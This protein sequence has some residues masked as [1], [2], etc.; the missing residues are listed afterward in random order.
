MN[1][2][3][4]KC[5][6]DTVLRSVDSFQCGVDTQCRK[7][8]T[9]CMPE[10]D[11]DEVLRRTCSDCSSISVCGDTMTMEVTVNGRHGDQKELQ[12]SDWVTKTSKR[13]AELQESQQRE[14]DGAT[15]VASTSSG[16]EKEGR[17]MPVGF[18]SDK[19]GV[20]GRPSYKAAEKK[21]AH[22]SVASNLPRG[23]QGY[24]QAQRRTDAHQTLG[25][26]DWWSSKDGSRHSMAERSG[27]GQDRCQRQARNIDIQHVQGG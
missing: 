9:H 7:T 4:Q 11:D 18:D 12:S 23:S 6:A 21:L 10:D 25:T 13:V 2:C 1:N 26:C 15:T 17:T 3:Y 16:C 5:G 20:S 27:G 24:Y 14:R 8:S 22:R 19:H